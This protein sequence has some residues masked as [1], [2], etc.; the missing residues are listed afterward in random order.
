MSRLTIIL[1]LKGGFTCK[2]AF[3]RKYDSTFTMALMLTTVCRLL[4]EKN[5]R[6]ELFHKLVQRKVNDKFSILLG[7]GKRF[8]LFSEIKISNVFHL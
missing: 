7:Y 6:I 2:I 8:I 4:T 3:P 1:S 5:I